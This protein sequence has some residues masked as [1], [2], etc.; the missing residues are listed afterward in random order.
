VAITVRKIAGLI[1]LD[2]EWSRGDKPDAVETGFRFNGVWNLG[3]DPAGRF[4]P[5]EKAEARKVFEAL[6]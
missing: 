2:T 3:R 5:A 1:F 4:Q 6:V